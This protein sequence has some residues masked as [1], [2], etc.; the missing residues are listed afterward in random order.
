MSA[1]GFAARLS[2]ELDHDFAVQRQGAGA[3]QVVFS[4]ASAAERER[5]IAR[6]AEITG[7]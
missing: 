6:I 5:L 4:A 3:Y 1:K 2:R 7:Q